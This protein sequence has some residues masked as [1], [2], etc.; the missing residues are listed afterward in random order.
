M[1]FLLHFYMKCKQVAAALC[2]LEAKNA[3]NIDDSHSTV[4][5]WHRIVKSQNR[6]SRVEFCYLYSVNMS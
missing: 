3:L 6:T 5:F 4:L 1:K 2:K